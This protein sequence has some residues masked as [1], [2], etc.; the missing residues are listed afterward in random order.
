MPLSEFEIKRCEKLV[1]QYLEKRRPP[2]YTRN[3]LD[4]GFRIKGQSVE[5][6]E[7]RPHWKKS[8]EKIESAIAK[9]TYVKLTG[10]WK[11]YWQRADLKW[12]SYKPNPEVK[13]IEEFL[14]V[15]ELDEYGCFYG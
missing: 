15:V 14:K 5:L 13:N 1:G 3:E 7:I 9:S 4:F 6:F 11:I 2:A 12:H 8:D 10:T